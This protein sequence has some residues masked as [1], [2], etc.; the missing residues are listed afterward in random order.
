LSGEIRVRPA[1]EADAPLTGAEAAL[2]EDVKEL[3][4]NLTLEEKAALCVGKDY[5]TLHGVPRL[6]VPSIWV[7]DGPQAC[8]S[9]TAATTCP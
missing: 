4:A 2:A 5:W 8:A 7:A 9:S 3:L 1:A 6:G